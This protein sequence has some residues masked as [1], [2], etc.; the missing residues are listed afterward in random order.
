MNLNETI[1]KKIK[2]AILT[3][4]FYPGMKL[5]ENELSY[6]FGIS[7]TPIRESFQRLKQEG[8]INSKA[9]RR[10]FFVSKITAEDV[11]EVLK[12][13]EVLEGL[14]VRLFTK[15]ASVNEKRL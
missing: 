15:V 5:D 14:A 11:I 8:F 3:N 2:K 9:K 6:L 12:M 7:R 10:G 1:Y 4:K 13:R